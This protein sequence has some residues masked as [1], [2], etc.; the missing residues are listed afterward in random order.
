M[1]TGDLKSKID[2]LWLDFFAGGIANPLTVIEQITYLMFLRLLDI[3][4]SKLEKK[5]QRTGKPAGGVYAILDVN[6]GKQSNRSPRQ[7][8]GRDEGRRGAGKPAIPAGT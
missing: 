7:A 5:A 8:T 3:E 6:N 1:I 4:E 2:K